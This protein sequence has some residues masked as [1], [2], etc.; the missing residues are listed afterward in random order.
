MAVNNVDAKD[1]LITDHVSN[2]CTFPKVEKG[3][4]LIVHLEE[5]FAAIE[6]R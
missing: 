2:C 4:H 5:D 1:F 3:E 6:S